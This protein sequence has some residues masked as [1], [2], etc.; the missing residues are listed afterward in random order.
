MPDAKG[1]FPQEYR[2][3]ALAHLAPA[4]C[5]FEGWEVGGCLSQP[6]EPLTGWEV[7]PEELVYP[8]RMREASLTQKGGGLA[9]RAWSVCQ[10]YR[11][12][13]SFLRQARPASPL[14]GQGELKPVETTGVAH[15]H[16]AEEL[17][18]RLEHFRYRT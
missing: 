17:N 12:R 2:P 13:H 14:H 6:W 10:M 5:P 8:E 9:L 18:S 1:P 16:Q 15:A 3:G 4:L 11:C 7:I